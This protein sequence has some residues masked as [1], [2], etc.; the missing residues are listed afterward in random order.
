M[1]RGFQE[2]RQTLSPCNKEPSFL[3]VLGNNFFSFFAGA[4][5]DGDGITTAFDVERQVA[6]HHCHT[7]DADL[8]LG[9]YILLSGVVTATYAVM[10]VKQ[11]VS[12]N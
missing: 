8:L 7:D 4:V 3:R 11:I 6:P 1:R 10:L 2:T 12:N 9:H 5:E